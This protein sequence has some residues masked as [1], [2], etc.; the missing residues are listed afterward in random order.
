MGRDDYR[1]LGPITKL[2]LPNLDESWHTALQRDVSA[3]LARIMGRIIA[4]DL[5]YVLVLHLQI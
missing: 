5:N 4:F 1:A 3:H 2:V